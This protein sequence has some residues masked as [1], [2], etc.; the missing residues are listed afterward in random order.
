MTI[1]V[2]IGSSGIQLNDCQTLWL[3]YSYLWW[4]CSN[5][6]GEITLT[7]LVLDE[8]FFTSHKII[9]ALKNFCIIFES[10]VLNQ[11]QGKIIS[12]TN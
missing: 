4:I 10:K 9:N 8:I 7:K 6:Q 11:I 1:R 12:V 2:V 3:C 5:Q